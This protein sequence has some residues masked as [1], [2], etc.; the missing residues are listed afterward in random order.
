M[1]SLPTIVSLFIW[2]S[3]SKDITT[4]L[5]AHLS[6]SSMDG[7]WAEG[8]YFPLPG[9]ISRPTIQTKVKPKRSGLG[10]EVS[11]LPGV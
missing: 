8:G 9:Q 3:A 5:S 10:I 4:F 1:P 6:I 11:S 2:R 7:G